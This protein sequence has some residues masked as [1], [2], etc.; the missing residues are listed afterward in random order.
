MASLKLP[1]TW[2]LKTTPVPE[3]K[4]M[5]SGQVVPVYWITLS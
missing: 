4:L 2:L 3:R 1:V 5:A